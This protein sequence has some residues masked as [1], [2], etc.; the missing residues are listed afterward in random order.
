MI[1]LMLHILYTA[2]TVSAI[3]NKVL[4]PALNFFCFVV[5]KHKENEHACY[6]SIELFQS[7]FYS[8]QLVS[9]TATTTRNSNNL[10]IIIYI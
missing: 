5:R 9:S 7:L 3:G 6:V 8:V 10:L 4:G 2:R 1:L